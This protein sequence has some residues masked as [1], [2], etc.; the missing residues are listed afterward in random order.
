MV[1]GAPV[2]CSSSQPQ[3]VQTC[4]CTKCTADAARNPCNAAGGGRDNLTTGVRLHCKSWADNPLPFGSEMSWDS[5]G[6]EEA[7]G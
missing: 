6:Q 7:C 4:N 5:T 1:G 2:V 3:Y